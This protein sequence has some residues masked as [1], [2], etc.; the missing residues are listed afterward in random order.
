[1]KAILVNQDGF[2]FEVYRQG[3]EDS[4]ERAVWGFFGTEWPDIEVG[5]PFLT[6]VLS[7]GATTKAK[8]SGCSMT[9][10]CDN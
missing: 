1:M 8:S 7:S 5:D 9:L 6:T 4:I 10:N 3:I 2:E